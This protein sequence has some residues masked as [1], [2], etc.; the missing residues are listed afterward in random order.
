MR[1]NTPRMKKVS[2]KQ[3]SQTGKEYRVY[4]G[5]GTAHN[6]SSRRDATLFLG[7]TNEYL[8]RKLYECKE[9]YTS[10]FS[11]Y[12]DN[13]GYFK[14]D[15]KT[16]TVEFFDRDRAAQKKLSEVQVSLNFIVDRCHH[17]NG[18][19]FTFSHF[20]ALL[21]NLKDVVKILNWINST[22]SK[23]EELYAYST[24]FERIIKVENDLSNYGQETSLCVFRIPEYLEEQES[25]Y[26]PKLNIA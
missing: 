20:R 7:K 24:I 10:V 11:R 5:N 8:T 22:R 6:F 17:V 1:N 23:R 9:L 13:W 4:L 19:Y 12:Q 25:E 16:F 26:I 14:H 18:N 3:I 15:K 2:L 21:N